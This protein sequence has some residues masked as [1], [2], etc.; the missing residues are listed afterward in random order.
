M[1]DFPNVEEKT[2]SGERAEGSTGTGKCFIGLD[3]NLEK[4]VGTESWRRWSDVFK[5]LDGTQ[6]LMQRLISACRAQPR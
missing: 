4:P 1:A 6:Q 2:H 3:R 5:I